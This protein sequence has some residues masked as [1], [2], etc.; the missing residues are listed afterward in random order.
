TAKAAAFSWIWWPKE[1]TQGN[2]PSST[3]CPQT[4]TYSLAEPGTSTVASVGWSAVFVVDGNAWRFEPFG[5]HLL[6]AV[7]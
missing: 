7:T 6:D 2:T 1:I 5:G 3:D 4:Q